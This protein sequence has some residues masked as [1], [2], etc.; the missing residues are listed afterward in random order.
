MNTVKIGA[1]GEALAAEYLKALG[2]NIIKRNYRYRKSEIDIIAW[3]SETLVFLEVKSRSSEKYGCGAEAVNARKQKMLV[4][5]AYGFCSKNS[6]FECKMRF[7]VLEV[8]LTLNKVVRH[9]ENAF[10]AE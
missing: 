3:E 1:Y 9:I 10:F 2:Y 8:D 4:S 6:L 7:D 5:G